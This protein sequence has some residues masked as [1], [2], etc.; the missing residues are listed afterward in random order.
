MPTLVIAIR[1]PRSKLSPAELLDF[2][3]GRIAKWWMPDDVL[4]VEEL[5]HCATGKLLKITLRELYGARTF[6]RS[7]GR[8][9]SRDALPQRH[10]GAPLS[11]AP[12]Y[13]TNPWRFGLGCCC[14]CRPRWII[15]TIRGKFHTRE[16]YA[17]FDI[18]TCDGFAF[19]A[20]RDSSA[21]VRGRRGLKGMKR[22]KGDPALE[23]VSWHIDV[24]GRSCRTASPK[25]QI[26]GEA[27]LMA[28]NGRLN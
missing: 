16:K 8:L 10:N 14:A 23:I 22:D 15:A 28:E 4:F 2:Y 27:I 6:R 17:E 1:R 18:V 12:R 7:I 13:G 25:L 19:I 5:P 11:G 3:S 9:A 26:C 21:L 20:D 24:P